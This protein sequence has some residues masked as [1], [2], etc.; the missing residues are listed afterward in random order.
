MIIHQQL[1]HVLILAKMKYFLVLHH[2]VN[3][4]YCHNHYYYNHYLYL[5]LNLI[6]VNFEY[7]FL[8]FEYLIDA[9]HLILYHYMLIMIYHFVVYTFLL[10]DHLLKIIYILNY[11]TF[12]SFLMQLNQLHVNLIHQTLGF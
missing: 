12:F 5:Y 7:I 6:Y 10:L 3:V 9:F 1:N 8:F 2:F 4:S 11:M